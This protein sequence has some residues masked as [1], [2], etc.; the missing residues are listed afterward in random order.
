MKWKLPSAS[1]LQGI[2]F[3]VVKLNLTASYQVISSE[4]SLITSISLLVEYCLQYL[5]VKIFENQQLEIILDLE[6]IVLLFLRDTSASVQ[7]SS[8]CCCSHSSYMLN[9]EV[10]VNLAKALLYPKLKFSTELT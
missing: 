6:N 3:A 7:A 2:I 9:S 1:S 4:C 10:A 5:A 8:L